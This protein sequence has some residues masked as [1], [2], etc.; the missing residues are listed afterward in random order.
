MSLRHKAIELASVLVMLSKVAIAE[1]AAE[2]ASPVQAFQFEFTSFLRD[3]PLE[4]DQLLGKHFSEVVPA[5][6]WDSLSTPEECK[7]KSIKYDAFA[8]GPFMQNWDFMSEPYCVSQ[9][10]WFLLFFNRGFVFRV[11][12]RFVSDS[13]EGQIESNDPTFCGDETPIFAAIAKKLGGSVTPARGR[14]EIKRYTDTYVMTL[15]TGD[16][17]TVWS[18]DLRGGPSELCGYVNHKKW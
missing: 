14:H 5:Q 2:P 18:W 16:H 1:E 8:P 17:N 13:F 15:W 12:L 6:P 9:H 7:N 11:E 4:L 10:S 3:R